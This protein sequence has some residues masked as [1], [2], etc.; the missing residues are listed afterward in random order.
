MIHDQRKGSAAAPC[1]SGQPRPFGMKD[2]LGYM[3]GDFAN[4]FFFILVSSFLMVFYTNVLGINPAV[5]GILFV[6]ARCVDAF[7]DIGMGQLVDRAKMNP[8]GRYR[9][10][11]LRMKLPAV[12]AGI[13]V[14]IP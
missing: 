9:I 1:Q 7:T 2:K 12:V 5:V 6:A 10:W 4:D 3:F 11:I 14:F 8:Y 13:L